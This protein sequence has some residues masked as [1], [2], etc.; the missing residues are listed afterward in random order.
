M[1][2]E[3]TRHHEQKLAET[4][5]GRIRSEKKNQ[6]LGIADLKHKTNMFYRRNEGGLNT[7]IKNKHS[8]K[9][10]TKNKTE[11]N[12]VLEIKNQRMV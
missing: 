4:M 7:L 1:V 2:P 3:E 12:M 8:P 11:Q 10:K 6:I 9:S 5:G